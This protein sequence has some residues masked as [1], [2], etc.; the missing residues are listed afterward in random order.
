MLDRSRRGLG[1][2]A[3]VED[4]HRNAYLAGMP[5]AQI[6]QVSK[7]LH[8]GPDRCIVVWREGVGTCG[9]INLVT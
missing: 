2:R 3:S 7:A 5:I 8:T 4:P 9:G 1:S 6:G